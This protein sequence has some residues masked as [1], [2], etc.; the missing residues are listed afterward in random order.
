MTKLVLLRNLEATM[1]ETSEEDEYEEPTPASE[2][3]PNQHQKD[4]AEWAAM[5]AALDEELE[6]QRQAEQDERDRER[7]S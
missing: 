2:L 7:L 1:G 3:P 4:L 5:E 6:A